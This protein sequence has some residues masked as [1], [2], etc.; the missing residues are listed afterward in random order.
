MGWADEMMG[1]Q[2]QRGCAVIHDRGC[3]GLTENGQRPFDVFTPVASLAGEK[4]EFKIVV[5]AANL[6]EGF[7]C[8]FGKG[9]ATKVCVNDNSGSVNERLEATGPNL[10]NRSAENSK[11]RFNFWD[12]AAGP[13]SGEL[14][15]HQIHH[16]R[17]RQ[18]DF[19]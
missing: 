9:R 11:D 6:A 1:D 14:P 18:I 2:H 7:G 8:P 4:I 13:G 3:F 15:S 16:Q 5:T 12:S 19:A 17:P 10:F